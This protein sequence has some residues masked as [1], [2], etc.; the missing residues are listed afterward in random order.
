[1]P[2]Y[3]Q[4]E[5]HTGFSTG[6]GVWSG[7]HAQI[8]GGYLTSGTSGNYVDWDDHVMR[9]YNRKIHSLSGLWG[10]ANT[11]LML[12]PNDAGFRY[13]GTGQFPAYP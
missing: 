12:E 13:T 4:D 2:R 11:G 10:T 7:Y 1:M 3:L 6:S 9:E 8:T 5:I